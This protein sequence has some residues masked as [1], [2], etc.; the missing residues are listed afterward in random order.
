M[1]TL[2]LYVNYMSAFAG[3]SEVVPNTSA[4]YNQKEMQ[5]FFFFSM[6]HIQ[7]LPELSL[8]VH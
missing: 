3:V 5:T 4:Y 8:N 6:D 1:L 2:E 7:Q